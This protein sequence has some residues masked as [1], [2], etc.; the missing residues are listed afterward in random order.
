MSALEVNRPVSALLKTA[1]AAPDDVVI[2]DDERTVTADEMAHWA[3][4]IA[5]RLSDV[6]P[7]AIVAILA[8]LRAAA[9]AASF[10]GMW[11]GASITLLDPAEPIAHLDDLVRRI[12]P[13]HVIDATGTVGR[14]WL[15][16]E[17]ID[18]TTVA[19]ALPE[20]VAVHPDSIRQIV[21]TSGSTGRPKAIARHAGAANEA[22]DVWLRDAA[23]ITASSA[24]LLPIQFT[25]GFGPA[26]SGTSIGRR[27]LLVD[28]R[29]LIL[30]EATSSV[31]AETEAI[32][33]AAIDRLVTGR[34]TIAIAHRLSTLRRA[35]RLVVLDAGRIVEVGTHEELLATDGMY[36]RL[37]HAQMKAAEEAAASA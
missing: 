28:P 7:G 25:G 11:A 24:L 4:G 6:P 9:I 26:V 5:D 30:D 18:A 16:L 22:Y 3:G 23:N 13:T 27:S 32:I 21:F 36:A 2:D 8:D 35:N 31:D 12:R 37:Y 10:G 29:I 17:V 1:A 33:Q 14:T 34:T 20:P 15:G 19:P